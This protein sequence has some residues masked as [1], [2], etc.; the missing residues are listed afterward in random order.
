[1]SFSQRR[2]YTQGW[3][4]RINH[5]I[6]VITTNLDSPVVAVQRDVEER[7]VGGQPEGDVEETV[8]GSGEEPDGEDPIPV[9]GGRQDE[10]AVKMD[11]LGEG[12]GIAAM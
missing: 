1:M 3:D 8:G 9:F 2:T 11:D 12:S 5:Q 6:S 7:G 4:R 10:R